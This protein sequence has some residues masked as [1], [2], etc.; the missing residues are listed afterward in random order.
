MCVG[1]GGGGLREGGGTGRG[2]G[3]EDRNGVQ[4]GLIH[5]GG[6]QKHKSNREV[7]KP[8]YGK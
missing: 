3:G 4:Q 1:G 5:D 7:N 8:K 2:G 6:G